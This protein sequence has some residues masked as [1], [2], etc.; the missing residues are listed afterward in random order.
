MAIVGSGDG[1]LVNHIAEHIKNIFHANADAD[2][3]VFRQALIDLMP[4]LYAS[5]AFVSYPRSDATNVYTQ[6]LVAVRPNYREKAALF[7]INSS[8]V[9][10]VHNGIRIIGCGTMEETAR[11][12]EMDLDMGES[13]T[14]ALYLIYEA[15]RHYS[16][17]GGVT[18]VYSLP[19]PPSVPGPGR[20]PL[21]LRVVDQGQKE[22]LFGGLRNWHYRILV[23][24]G[25]PATSKESFDALVGDYADDLHRIRQEFEELEK[26]E[27]ARYWRNQKTKMEVIKK[28]L[29][30]GWPK[31]NEAKM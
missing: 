12:L 24:V 4:R 1:N 19:H 20:T 14:A 8:L 11:E 16:Y 6:L 27:I 26:Q 25:S 30:D 22:H 28:T 18:H 23:S 21:A 10:E 31:K 29:D 3:S 2:L 7:L 17:V 5:E 13:T 9:D 15:K